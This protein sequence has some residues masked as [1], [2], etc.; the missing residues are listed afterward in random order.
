MKVHAAAETAQKAYK[1]TQMFA[2]YE[3]VCNTRKAGE[4][5]RPTFTADNDQLMDHYANTMNWQ[6]NNLNSEQVGDTRINDGLSDISHKDDLPPET[7]DTIRGAN[8]AN[9][10]RAVLSEFDH[11]GKVVRSNNLINLFYD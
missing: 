1:N 2:S 10:R 11:T 6:N 7:M 5:G 3:E 4:Q 8:E 9:K